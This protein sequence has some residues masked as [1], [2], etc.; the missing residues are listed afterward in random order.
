MNAKPIALALSA[1]MLLSLATKNVKNQTLFLFS[2]ISK[3]LKCYC[4]LKFKDMKK[5]ISY[6][7]K[8]LLS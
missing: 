3:S 8:Q 4:L 7:K 1:M 6:E 5:Y 2:P